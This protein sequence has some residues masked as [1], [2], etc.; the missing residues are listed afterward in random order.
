MYGPKVTISRKD[1]TCRLC[2]TSIPAGTVV[3]R[4]YGTQFVYHSVCAHKWLQTRRIECRQAQMSL[5]RQV[6]TM[7]EKAIAKSP[8]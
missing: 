3:V 5:G 6:K 1:Q 2:N 4:M 8:L 7:L